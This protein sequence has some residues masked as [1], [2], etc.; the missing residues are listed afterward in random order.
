MLR[1]NATGGN[2]RSAD[3]PARCSYDLSSGHA[4]VGA[5]EYRLGQSEPGNSEALAEGP[6]AD[7][8]NG[9]AH[10]EP[11]KRAA[12]QTERRIMETA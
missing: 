11:M 5:C 8:G 10:D 2:C 3:A 9:M 4:F 7:Q 6:D 12:V 1:K